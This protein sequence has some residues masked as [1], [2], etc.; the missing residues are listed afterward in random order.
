MKVLLISSLI[1]A[2]R[3]VSLFQF[4]FHFRISKQNIT[5]LSPWDFL[6]IEVFRMTLSYYLIRLFI[7]LDFNSGNIDYHDHKLQFSMR[8]FDSYSDHYFQANTFKK[9]LTSVFVYF[10][11]FIVHSWGPSHLSRALFSLYIPL[12]PSPPLLR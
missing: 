3:I 8:I 4:P 1:P 2:T 11:F 5:L 10:R 12:L 9:I 7:C 6:C